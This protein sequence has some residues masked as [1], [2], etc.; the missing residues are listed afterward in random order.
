M[1]SEKKNERERESGGSEYKREVELAVMNVMDMIGDD[2]NAENG[3][4]NT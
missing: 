1:T 3:K 4:A 2:I